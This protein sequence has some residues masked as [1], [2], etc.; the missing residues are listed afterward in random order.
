MSEPSANPTDNSKKRGALVRRWLG[1]AAG[2]PAIAVELRDTRRMFRVRAGGARTL[3]AMYV[4]V[5]DSAVQDGF[6][7]DGDD[8]QA[9]LDVGAVA[10]RGPLGGG[11]AG[12]RERVRAA[13]ALLDRPLTSYYLII[14]ITTLLLCLGL[15]MVLSTGSVNDLQ[16]GES[17]YHDFEWQLVGIIVGLPVMWLMAR[18]SPRVFRAMAYP[19]L[20]VSIIGLGLTLIP[21]VAVKHNDVARWIAIGP[22]TFQPSELAKLALAVWGADLLA[23]KEKL[24]MLADWRH[25]LLPLVPGAGLLALLVMAGDDLGTTSILLIILLALLWFGGMP[26]RVYTA[27]I[28][29][30]GLVLFLLVVAKGYGSARLTDFL[31]P[32][33]NP[34]GPD[35]Q[36]IQGTYGLGSGGWFGLGLGA[37][38]EQWG[39]LPEDSSDF[40]FAIIG[41]ELGLV[42]TLC[43]TALYG[44]LAFAGLRV[45][46]R[47]P[48]TFS[49]LAAATITAWIVMQAVVNIG[50]VIGVFP[51]TGVPLPLVSQGLSSVLV[52]M[53][54]LGMLMSFARREPGA[55]QALAARGP[56]V[57]SRVLS[58]LSR[59]G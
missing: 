40:I 10:W 18:S 45:A 57:G 47:A 23:R 4:R 29:L 24:G 37:S 1:W 21:G 34:V 46:R 31:H 48:D 19:L 53:V 5:G 41:E 6:S 25:M 55:S 13:R 20:A 9:V 51:I 3:D 59:G 52:T 49:R 58:W 56:G 32:D 11:I 22:I 30:M 44:G 43:V 17:P 8:E 39:Y 15:M 28:I 2:E 12:I 7:P 14:G 42:G 26:T 35:Q 16:Q 36:P 50:A 33:T 54:G 27:L 38:K